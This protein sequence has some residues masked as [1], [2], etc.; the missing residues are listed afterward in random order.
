[1]K[2]NRILMI[3]QNAPYPQDPRVRNEAHALA[4]AGYAVT[5]LAPRRGDQ[6][7]SETKNQVNIYRFPTPPSGKGAIAYGIEYFYSLVA[8][9]I[10][11]FWAY[12]RRGFDAIHVANPPD[13][14]CLVAMPYK[15]LGKRFIYDHHDLCPELYIERFGNNGSLAL[16]M[17]YKFER[18]SCRL[19]DQVITTNSSH[20]ALEIKRANI[21]REK[22]A[23]VRNGPKLSRLQTR[24]APDAELR[25]KSPNII[26]YA[27]I[28]GFQ[29]GLDH[30][31]RAIRRL[32]FDLGREDFCC[33]I[34]GDGDA[35][36]DIKRMVVELKIDDKVWFAGW[37]N[38]PEQ[39][40]KYVATADICVSPEPSNP[41]NDCS[42][43]IKIMEYMGAGKPIVAFDVPETRNSAG[44]AAIY[45]ANNDEL[46]FAKAL[47]RLMEDAALRAEMGQAGRARIEKELAWEYSAANLLT[48]Y[49]GMFGKRVLV[50]S[51]S[52]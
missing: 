14:L 2:P 8:I 41:Y 18:L 17:L 19:A 48:A 22:I 29:D 4:E 16:R 44:P 47:Q 24:T 11:T 49:A 33:A 30:L 21:A 34:V 13:V 5:V 1:M 26:M 37:I 40:A 31:C 23:I 43:L 32:R 52:A 35:M 15:L 20:Q 45:A 51:T 6:H 46:E 50:E 12:L 36:P 39:Y 3:V 25:A 27:G 9:S 28:T 38:D 10:L 7:W 42:T